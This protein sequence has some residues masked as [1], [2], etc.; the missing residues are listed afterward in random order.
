MYHIDTETLW[1]RLY[2]SP[3]GSLKI[4]LFKAKFREPKSTKGRQKTL[5]FA[6]EA[7]VLV[8]EPLGDPPAALRRILFKLAPRVWACI[9]GP[10]RYAK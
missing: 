7:L 6:A 3:L 8:P 4:T 9:P 2:Y 5:S 10:Q 1:V